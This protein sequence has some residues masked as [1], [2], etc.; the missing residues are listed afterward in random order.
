MK[1]NPLPP[2]EVLNTLLHYDPE[3]GEFRWKQLR[4]N[5]ISENSIAGHR[6]V[7]GYIHIKISGKVYKAHRLAYKM[8]YGIEPDDILDHIDMNRSN[9][10]ILNLRIATRSQN[11]ANSKVRSHS[12]TG[13]KGVCCISNRFRARIRF[14]KK[15]IFL[16]SYQTL[17]EAKSAY[18]KAA[19]EYYGEFA[20]TS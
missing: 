12:L 5:Q 11:V 15:E 3:T 16:G 1:I 17:E 14:D 4:R 2:L 9:N 20:R 19:K 10:R 6:H 18:D 7:S 8:Y 13:V